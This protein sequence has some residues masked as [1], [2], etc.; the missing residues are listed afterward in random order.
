MVGH[1]L[2]DRA[3]FALRL[4][5]KV[6]IAAKNGNDVVLRVPTLQTVLRRVPPLPKLYWTACPAMLGWDL[7]KVE[8]GKALKLA[9]GLCSAS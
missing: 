6:V 1:Y 2:V 4:T 8:R 7:H 5:Q 9:G 3:W